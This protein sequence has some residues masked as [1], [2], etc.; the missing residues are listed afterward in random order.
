MSGAGRV[1]SLS[2]VLRAPAVVFRYPRPLPRRKVRWLRPAVLALLVSFAAPELGALRIQEDRVGGWL[3]AQYGAVSQAVESV[4][5]LVGSGGYTSTGQYESQD[6]PYTCMQRCPVGDDGCY[7][8]CLDQK[9]PRGP[10]SM[11]EGV[12]QLRD[13]MVA[14]QPLY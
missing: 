7:L 14:R 1:A 4:T 12:R 2:E 11:P 10:A 9:W 3:M 6:L 8:R 5:L 13:E